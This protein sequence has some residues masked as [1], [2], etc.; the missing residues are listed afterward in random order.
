MASILVTGGTGTLGRQLVRQLTYQGFDVGVLTTRHDFDLPV[1]ARIYH[2][3]LLSM[4]GTEGAIATK[5]VIIH[6]ASNPRDAEAVDVPGTKNLL[7]IAARKG[8]SHF[9][10]VSI[11]GVDKSDYPYYRV[12]HS[13]EKIV[14]ESGVPWTILR[15]TQFHDLVL[16]RLIEPFGKND[17]SLLAIPSGLRFQSIDVR[18][19]ANR[20]QQLAL[21]PPQAA[22]MTLAGPEVLTLEE[23][24]RTYLR[25]RGRQAGIQPL[26]LKSE[27]Y[28]LFRSGANI[29]PSWEKG[30]I[31]WE[32][33]LNVLMC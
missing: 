5:A 28:D 19:V 31:T 11:A 9:I 14:Q 29:D 21:G 32:E 10:Y 27:L 33:Y 12:K 24:T 4:E 3:D 8:V 25:L 16:Y 26:P 23:M 17:G 1:G 7:D 13:V 30:R 18:D 15:A 20:L 6:A 22:T 2:G